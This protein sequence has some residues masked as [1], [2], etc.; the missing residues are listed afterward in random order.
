MKK[1]ITLI[2]VLSL[3]IFSCKAQHIIPVE[4]AVDYLDKEDG[5]MDGKDYV[6]VKDINNLLTKFT[7]T[8]KGTYNSKNFEFKIVKT[9]TDDGELKEDLLLARYKITDSNG[10]V[11][12]NTL[13]LPDDSPYVLF[14]GYIIKESI[15]TYMLN[16]IG[17]NTNCGQNGNVFISV[18]GTNNTKMKLFLQVAGEMYFDCTTGAAKQVLP[19]KVVTLT[20]Q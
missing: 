3:S 13:D 15:Y 11:I 19:T 14:G 4:K 1:V 9:T 18:Y 6:Y 7:G 5:L 16:Y 8:W 10:R 12:E 20:K 2:L 17:K